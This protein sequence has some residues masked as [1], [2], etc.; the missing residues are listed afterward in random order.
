MKISMYMYQYNTHNKI[1]YT[2]KRKKKRLRP[3]SSVRM[4]LNRR[5]APMGSVVFNHL[6]TDECLQLQTCSRTRCRWTR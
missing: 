3:Q 1:I 6:H 5:N 2:E 4:R